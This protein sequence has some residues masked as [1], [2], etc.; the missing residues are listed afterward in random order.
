[1]TE[2]TTYRV[3]KIVKREAYEI[4]RQIGLKPSQ[5]INLFLSQVALRGGIPFEIKGRQPN[6]E[7]LEAFE[8]GKKLE[9]LQSFDSFSD[10]R[11][12]LDV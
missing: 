8:E 12:D 10:I 6:K 9:E 11:S 7:T 3:D 4:F 1:M 2:S 5:A